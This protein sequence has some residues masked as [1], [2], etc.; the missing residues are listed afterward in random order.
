MKLLLSLSESIDIC[1]TNIEWLLHA[2][3]RFP[4]CIRT[5]ASVCVVTIILDGGFVLIS[6]AE[7]A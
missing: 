2:A 1:R 5:K 7:D 3:L 4:V 6:T